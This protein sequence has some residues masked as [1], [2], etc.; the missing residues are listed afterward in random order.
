MKLVKFLQ[1]SLP[2]NAGEQA[3][4]DDATAERLVKSGKAEYIK[5]KAAAK[6]EAAKESAKPQG[7]APKPEAQSAHVGDTLTQR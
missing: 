5:A 4:F 6:P 1:P 2:Y 3:G 7:E